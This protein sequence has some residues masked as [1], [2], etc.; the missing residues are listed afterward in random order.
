MDIITGII[1]FFLILLIIVKLPFFKPEHINSKTVL[2]SFAFRS[3]ACVIFFL[4]YTFYYTNR[5]EADMYRYFDDGKIMYSSLQAE[6]VSYVKM[7]S[8]ISDNTDEIRNNYYMNMNTWFKS[9][10]NI[11]HNDNRTM[12]RLNAFLMLFTFGSFYANALIFMFLGFTGLV[13]IYKTMTPDDPVKSKI[14][15]FLLMFFPSLVFW[16]SNITKESMVIFTLGGFL[17]FCKRF[18]TE[19]RKYYRIILPALFLLLLFLLKIY[20]LLSLIPFLL[21]FLLTVHKKGRAI[22]LR[23]AIIITC[24]ILLLWNFNVFFPDYNIVEAFVSQQR[25]F[26]NF[27][28]SVNAGSMLFV[29]ELEANV[30][31]FLKATPFALINVLFRPLFFDSTNFLMLFAS[32][33]NAFVILLMFATCYFV[34][35]KFRADAFFAAC[36]GFTIFFFLVVGLTTPVS[37][38]IVRYK[39]IGV[40]FLFFLLISLVDERN[41]KQFLKFKTDRNE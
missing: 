38:A 18:L 19:P 6:S 35:K 29:P 40:P 24:Y 3:I 9:F 20:V 27:A 8:G 17:F 31:S 2:L 26:L 10:E 7:I 5:S 1:Y 13:W 25:N 34:R 16:T 39:I 32:V 30:L 36:L 41:L 33:E 28:E 4:V 37:G 21:A 14:L 12:V 22:L 15:F 11:V 23:F